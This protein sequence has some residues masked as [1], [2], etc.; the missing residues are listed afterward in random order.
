MQ[1]RPLTDSDLLE[2]AAKLTRG[3]DI[4]RLGLKLGLTHEEI[5][6]NV[7]NHKDEITMAAYQM[8]HT[9]RVQQQDGKVAFNL[10]VTALEG[11]KLQ[12]II[13]EV[14]CRH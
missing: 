9:W 12:R 5:A 7:K 10:L 11:S 1:N 8:L 4:Y 6:V 2:V 13:D 14:F 3:L